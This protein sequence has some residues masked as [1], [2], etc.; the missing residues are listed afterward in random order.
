[1][2]SIINNNLITKIYWYTFRENYYY[3]SESK[4]DTMWMYDNDISSISCDQSCRSFVRISWVNGRMNDL[5]VF[6]PI[7][8]TS[9]IL[10]AIIPTQH[11]EWPHFCIVALFVRKKFLD[12]AAW[13]SNWIIH[14]RIAEK[15][16]GDLFFNEISILPGIIS[17]LNI[18]YNYNKIIFIIIYE[19]K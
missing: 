9:L 6:F 7:W 3:L 5:I 18:I 2:K 1:M 12:L 14:R 19:I 16:Q 4:N 10:F 17:Q 15:E 8:L 13:V 11:S